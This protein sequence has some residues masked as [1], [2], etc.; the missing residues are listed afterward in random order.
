MVLQLLPLSV[1]YWIFTFPTVP[2]EVQVI[3]Y[4]DPF[5]INSPP[6]G[7]VTVIV[8]VV[9]DTMEKLESDVSDGLPSDASLTRTRQVVED[10]LGTVQAYV[11]SLAVEA[12]TE[13]QVLP[14]LVE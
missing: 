4:E 11:P 9:L 14:L 3:L 13:L 8:G 10:L 7:A 6:S 2:T 12:V 5:S 1:E